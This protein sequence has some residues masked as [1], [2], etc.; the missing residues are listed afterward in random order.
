MADEWYVWHGGHVRASETIGDIGDQVETASAGQF[1][2]ITDP[3][4]GRSKLIRADLVL[5]IEQEQEE[6]Q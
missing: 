4:D 3:G 5:W 1:I 2:H 6:Q